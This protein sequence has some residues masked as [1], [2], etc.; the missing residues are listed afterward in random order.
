MAKLS[1]K[2]FTVIEGLLVVIAL[3]LVIGVGYYVYNAN[4]D[5]TNNSQTSQSQATQTAK[6]KVMNQSKPA[7]AQVANPENDAI[8][9]VI[10]KEVCRGTSEATIKQALNDKSKAL[11][12]G[13]FARVSASCDDTSSGFTSYLNK[14]EDWNIL[15]NTQQEPTCEPFDG[16]SVPA[17]IVD[18]CIDGSGT[19]RAPRQV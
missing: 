2:G 14:R 7:A 16:L 18:K 10:A 11:I 1:Q 12:D 15:L 4:K 3:S 13:K 5:D 19:E 9:A 8:A 6:K 17:T